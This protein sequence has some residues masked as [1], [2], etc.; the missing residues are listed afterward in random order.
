[1][2]KYFNLLYIYSNK[3]RILTVIFYSVPIILDTS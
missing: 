3:T 2:W 1:M